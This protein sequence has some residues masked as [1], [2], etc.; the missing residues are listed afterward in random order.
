MVMF[1]DGTLN[2]V[3]NAQRS[4][5]HE[6]QTTV[7]LVKGTAGAIAAKIETLGAAT[8]KMSN[9]FASRRRKNASAIMPSH[10]YS[11]QRRATASSFPRATRRSRHVN[12]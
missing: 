4:R 6:R 9:V 11:R 7:W 3:K 12:H 8:N 2:S 10:L 1:E 5:W